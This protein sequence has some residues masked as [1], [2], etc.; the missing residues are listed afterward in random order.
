MTRIGKY[1]FDARLGARMS[2]RELGRRAGC[3]HAFVRSVEQGRTLPSRDMVDRIAAVL[4]FD[5]N[6]WA[7]PFARSD[8]AFA[9]IDR[10]NA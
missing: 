10:W 4:G 8:V 6:V 1:L 2:A 7:Y 9:A 3:T 5:P